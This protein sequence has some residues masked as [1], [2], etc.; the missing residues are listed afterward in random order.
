M[1]ST[2][3]AWL[4]IF[5]SHVLARVILM[6]LWMGGTSRDSIVIRFIIGAMK[7]FEHYCA[8]KWK[9]LITLFNFHDFNITLLWRL[10]EF[11]CLFLFLGSIIT[12]ELFLHIRE[13]LGLLVGF[14]RLQV[15]DI[16]GPLQVCIQAATR[17]EV[18]NGV[19]VRE[20]TEKFVIKY[21]AWTKVN[22]MQLHWIKY[23]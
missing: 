11:K 23:P 7:V 1:Y 13:L 15:T 17:R 10:H 18:V 9:I 12:L 6:N 2:D 8:F 3:L 19:K 22:A 4:A 5:Q 20:Q 14:R 21:S 16:E